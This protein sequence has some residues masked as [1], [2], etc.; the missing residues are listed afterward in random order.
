MRFQVL[1]DRLLKNK[2]DVLLMFDSL[3]PHEVRA[4]QEGDSMDW[5]LQT[6]AHVYFKTIFKDIIDKHKYKRK[7]D[8][9]FVLQKT[10]SET[11]L[12]TGKVSNKDLAI[13]KADWAQL[14]TEL[15][16]EGYM[17]KSIIC[18]GSVALEVVTKR[19]KITEV[20]YTIINDLSFPEGTLVKDEPLYTAVRHPINYQ[21]NATSGDIP[22]Y[23]KSI[24][25]AMFY[26]FAWTHQN[27]KGNIVLIDSFEKLEMVEKAVAI[28]KEIVLD[29]ESS[30]LEIKSDLARVLCFSLTWE[31]NQAA[32][33]PWMHPDIDLTKL[34]GSRTS[35]FMSRSLALLKT[36]DIKYIMHNGKY[37]STYMNSNGFEISGCWFDT[38]LAH[39]V[40]VDERPK[41][42]GLKRLAWI[43]TDRGG[44]EECLSA[45]VNTIDREQLTH[46]EY[47]PDSYVHIP[48]EVLWVYNGIDTVVTF[49]LYEQYMAILD[50]PDTPCATCTFKTCIGPE[51]ICYLKGSPK[52]KPL[53]FDIIMP[54]SQALGDIEQNGAMINLEKA[55]IYAQDAA[56]RLRH[57][58]QK[59]RTFPEPA[60][61]SKERYENAVIE[62]NAEKAERNNA[63]EAL[64]NNKAAIEA[65]FGCVAEFKEQKKVAKKDITAV[66]K[67]L[68]K[69]PDNIELTTALQ[70]L[71]QLII[72]KDNEIAALELLKKETLKQLPRATVFRKKAPDP[73]DPSFAFNFASNNDLREL[74]YDRLQLKALK[75]TE[76]YAEPLRRRVLPTEET[77]N[78]LSTDQDALEYA[79]EQHP[80]PSSL[81]EYAILDKLHGT[82]L[83]PALTTWVQR[84]GRIHASHLI[85]GAVT[86]RTSCTAPN[87][88]NL[89]STDKTIKKLFVSMFPDGYV[90]NCDLSQAE[91]R[92]LACITKDPTLIE[93]YKNDRDLHTEVAARAYNI[94]PEDVTPEYRSR[95]KCINFGLAYGRGARSLAP[96]MQ[97]S[98]E[99][100]EEFIAKYFES[101]PKVKEW[102]DGQK[103]V[104]TVPG[105]GHYV[106]NLFGFRRRLFEACHSNKTRASG[107]GRQAVNSPIQGSS[108]QYTIAALTFIHNALK[109]SESYIMATVHDSIVIDTPNA[110]EAIRVGKLAKSLLEQAHFDWQK[111]AG[112]T[113]KAD[114]SVGINYGMQEGVDINTVTE[115]DL[116]ILKQN[117]MQ[118]EQE[119]LQKLKEFINVN[120][121]TI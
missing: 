76:K 58:E 19:K 45:F 44:Y 3:F 67:A 86:G 4:F 38:M 52:W 113:M 62:Y 96:D 115:A 111:E 53:F 39:F 100:A 89:P 77:F 15:K 119:D 65:T 106:E 60:A 32:V 24:E 47:P 21:Q 64:Q 51:P 36:A 48:F 69:D 117:Q 18:V 72:D 103:A 33:F 5:V 46:K 90:V 75:T 88:Q 87:L 11:T 99:E 108:A 116:V 66:K 34:F 93:A 9:G 84:D 35:E 17:P 12:E 70:Y 22:T 31:K 85:H 61:I 54:A 20:E 74:L 30:T 49:D 81:L 105:M 42:H 120:Q 121:E 82:Y 14:L 50:K 27:Y 73:E 112:V 97:V 109:G 68:Q 107:A 83:Q 13:L 41:T 40:I 23:I 57:L 79:A 28:H 78:S 16:Q 94:A 29:I 8:L 10:G 71:E 80:L 6:E 25:K 91:L 114:V 118:Q 37:D 2:P 55:Q 63:Y 98:V 7:Y 1:K 104:I 95:A 59:L 26:A 92:I 110:A 43:E 101:M 56:I 102:I